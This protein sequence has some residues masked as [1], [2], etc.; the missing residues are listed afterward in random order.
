MS[1]RRLGAV[2]VVIV[3]ACVPPA[4]EQLA[5]VAV[6]S[7]RS[8]A[9][10]VQVATREL[11][12]AGFEISASDTS[13]GTVTAKRTREKRGNF[14]YITCKFAENS[15]AETNLVSTLTVNVT[16]TGSGDAAD[17]QVR[18]TVLAASAKREPDR[19][20]VHGGHRTAGRERSRAHTVVDPLSSRATARD[21]LS[22][23]RG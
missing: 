23:A 10:I 14:D 2:L 4:P 1:S 19:L 5:P 22:G 6:R 18:G 17:V 8:R 12:A 21:L 20:R 15:L 9:E 13:A 16:A 11:T 3:G 7:T